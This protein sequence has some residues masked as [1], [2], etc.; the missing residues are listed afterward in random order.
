MTKG[1]ARKAVY[2]QTQSCLTSLS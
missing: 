1:V 2:L